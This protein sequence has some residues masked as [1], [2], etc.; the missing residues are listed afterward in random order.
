MF[1]LETLALT[2]WTINKFSTTIGSP[3]IME[4]CCLSRENFFNLWRR[5]VNRT[6]FLDYISYCANWQLFFFQI[7][8][9]SYQFWDCPLYSWLLTQNR[10][11]IPWKGEFT[12]RNDPWTGLIA[13][14]GSFYS[15]IRLFWTA[16]TIFSFPNKIHM[17]WTGKLRMMRHVHKFLILGRYLF[18][19]G[20][21]IVEWNEILFVLEWFSLINNTWPFR[22]II[23][24]IQ[25]LERLL[26]IISL[27]MK[28]IA[29]QD[30]KWPYR[31]NGRE[32]RIGHEWLSGDK[33]LHK[34]QQLIFLSIYFLYESCGEELMKWIFLLAPP[35]RFIFY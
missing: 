14:C 6:L 27:V 26:E 17:F 23:L 15:M 9:L 19:F 31:E 29:R 1:T 2:W 24:Q 35:C 5:K 12:I 30:I 20:Q 21:L 4:R 18:I 32:T 25:M 13:S 22:E 10:E 7:I 16:E 33:K 11:R 8:I 34:I 3:R 28:V